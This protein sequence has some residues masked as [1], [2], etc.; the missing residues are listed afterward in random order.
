MRADNRHSA[1]GYYGGRRAYV[2]VRHIDSGIEKYALCVRTIGI[3][4]PDMMTYGERTLR[5]G[6]LI[7][8]SKIARCETLAIFNPAERVYN[9]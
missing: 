4:W 9:E 1:T 6:T 5:P 3:A 2:A 8:T 7:A